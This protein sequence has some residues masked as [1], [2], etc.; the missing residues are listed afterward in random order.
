MSLN[1]IL[2]TKIKDPFSG[3]IDEFLMEKQTK[4]AQETAV[5]N[6]EEETEKPFVEPDTEDTPQENLEDKAENPHSE[7]DVEAPQDTLEDKA[8]DVEEEATE[9]NLDSLEDQ[10]RDLQDK[11]EKLKEEQETGIEAG[12]KK[13]GMEISSRGYSSIASIFFKMAGG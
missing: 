10:R 8:D 13:I 4:P 3:S 9:D 2:G 5:D 12:L 7:P 6:L 1:K 11:I